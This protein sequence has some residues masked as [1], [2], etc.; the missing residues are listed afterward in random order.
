MRRSERE[1][2]NKQELLDI[3]EGCRV[4]RLGFC[5]QDGA[6]IV[7]LNF[8]FRYDGEMPVFYF[9]GAK[10]G[11]KAELI[12]KGVCCGFEMDCGHELIEGETGC[13]YT[14]GY[15]SVMGKGKLSEILNPDEKKEA[16]SLLML[17]QTGLSFSFDDKAAASVMVFKLEA[18]EITGKQRTA[19]G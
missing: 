14:Y 1:V 2:K 19:D 7:P 15:Q 3:I 8:G 4:M 9:H 10:E 11:K 18:F 16:L 12:K 13:R 6:Y 5:E 17:H